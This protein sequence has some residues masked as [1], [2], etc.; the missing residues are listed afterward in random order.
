MYYSHFGLETMSD[1]GDTKSSASVS[2]KASVWV[3]RVAM[4]QRVQS[5]NLGCLVDVGVGV[6]SGC[7][8][9]S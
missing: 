1:V 2:V 7:K 6:L 9:Y 5:S 3:Y 4:L 8:A